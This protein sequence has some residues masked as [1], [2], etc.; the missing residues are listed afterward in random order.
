MKSGGKRHQPDR[1]GDEPDAQYGGWKVSDL[2]EEKLPEGYAARR[3]LEMLK[4]SADKTFFIGVG[5]RRP[6]R[7]LVAPK[8]Y[9]D[10]YKLDEIALPDA[11]LAGDGVPLDQSEK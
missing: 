11:A 1:R 10:M 4:Q 3:A 5:F 9:F 7:P 6:H 8:K 2:P